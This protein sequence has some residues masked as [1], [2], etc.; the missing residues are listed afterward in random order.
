MGLDEVYRY[1]D[2]HADS[3]IEDLVRLVRQPSVSAKGE[4]MEDC[5]KLVEEMMLK[6]GLNAR[7]LRGERGNPVV[8]GEVK[9][10]K[11]H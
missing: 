11:N 8:Y 2:E 5:A 7:I 6:V 9:S 1:I 4:S 3:F 10:E